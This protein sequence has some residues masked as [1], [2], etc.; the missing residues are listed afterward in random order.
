MVIPLHSIINVYLFK[1]FCQNK[2]LTLL[3]VKL[4]NEVDWVHQNLEKELS[5]SFWLD[6]SRVNGKFVWPDQTEVDPANWRPIAGL[7]GQ[8]NRG[9]DCLTMANGKPFDEPCTYD[10]VKVIC[11]G[12]LPTPYPSPE[13]PTGSPTTTTAGLTTAQ[14]ANF[15][16]DFVKVQAYDGAWY[17]LRELQTGGTFGDTF[18]DAK[19][20][21]F[22]SSSSR[23]W[24]FGVTLACH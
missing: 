18:D 3:T 8:L 20:N 12:T 19:V 16:N 10:R 7:R 21:V 5:T 24:I 4:P 23:F 6:V 13:V 17:L 22:T 15:L 11:K 14:V 1:E 2:N 9:G